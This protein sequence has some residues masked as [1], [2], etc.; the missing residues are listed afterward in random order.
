MT[1][2]ESTPNQTENTSHCSCHKTVNKNEEIMSKSL[3][4]S[5]NWDDILQYTIIGCGWHHGNSTLCKEGIRLVALCDHSC[6]CHASM[7][8]YDA[9]TKNQNYWNFANH[10][11]SRKVTV[12]FGGFREYSKEFANDLKGR[13]RSGSIIYIN[14]DERNSYV[15][16]NYP[17][18]AQEVP[19]VGHWAGYMIEKLANDNKL[20][21]SS[22]VGVGHSLGAHIIGNMGNYLR[23]KNMKMAHIIALDPAAPCFEDKLQIRPV[24]K[25]DA[26][27]VQVIHTNS[28]FFGYRKKIGHIDIYPN[29]GDGQ[30]NCWTNTCYH[31][32]AV[33]GLL[34]Y[35]I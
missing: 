14:W 15:M 26:N 16:S 27:V 12:L 10:L 5:E 6:N 32:Y 13:I 2:I 7:S 24:Y 4:D 9:E 1:P 17:R 19:F 23:E 25:I 11:K 3:N 31:R 28:G 20:D 8:V 29:G 18:V 34:D 21:V 33:I 30:P 22:M 35:W